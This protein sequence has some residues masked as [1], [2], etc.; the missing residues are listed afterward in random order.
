[1]RN[2]FTIAALIFAALLYGCQSE[3]LYEK[4]LNFRDIVK[5]KDG[6]VFLEGNPGK[7]LF[8]KVT[9]QGVKTSVIF[10]PQKGER[11]AR[12][13]TRSNNPDPKRVFAMTKPIDDRDIDIEEAMVVL[14]PNGVAPVRYK[15]NSTFGK[16]RIDPENHYAILLHTTSD[17]NSNGS[18]FN[19][20]EV[21]IIDLETKPSKSNPQIRSIGIGSSVIDT[22]QFIGS[23]KVAGVSRRLAAFSS[24]G[25]IKFIDI[26][27]STIGSVQVKLKKSD[28]SRQILPSKFFTRPSDDV[29]GPT[30]FALAQGISEIFAISLIPR[31][32][33]QPGF[34][35]TLNQ[36]DGGP[37]PSDLI[38]IEDGETPLL[39]V[40]NKKGNSANIIDIDTAD[41]FTLTLADSPKHIFLRDAKA[42]ELVMYGGS[43]AVS[44]LKVEG[45]VAGKGSNLDEVMIPSGVEEVIKLDDDR[46]LIA[47]WGEMTL[48]DLRTRKGTILMAPSKEEGWSNAKLHGENFFWAQKGS[49]RISILN[50]VNGHPESLVLDERIKAF[51]IFEKQGIGFVLHSTPTGRATLFPLDNAQRSSA[52][53]VDGF[54]LEGL[55]DAD[56]V[57]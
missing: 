44:F 33:K 6:L 30:I 12:I 31:P 16:V 41:V 52:F 14:E 7:L 17:A 50:L 56:E 1:M 8:L 15:I 5:V 26:E 46:L 43:G 53:A 51:Y 2:L 29:H 48:L 20:N 28:D 23:V 21:A 9:K 55:L 27:D 45:L 47:S 34:W 4:E 38:V 18:V 22:V 35:A 57:Q 3:G 40:V 13:F 19:P 42:P 39:V 24:E 32:D 36:F 37:S 10:E 49:D 11:I 25:V 54:W